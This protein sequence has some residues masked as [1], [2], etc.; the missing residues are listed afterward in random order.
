[1]P[2]LGVLHSASIAL[3]QEFTELRLWQDI[4]LA[5]Y[6]AYV[7][8]PGQTEIQVADEGSQHVDHDGNIRRERFVL[9]VGILRVSRLG[10][11]FVHNRALTELALN[12]VVIRNRIITALDWKFLNTPVGN[13][14]RIAST[15]SD[16]NTIIFDGADHRVEFPKDATVWHPSAKSLHTILTSVYAGGK[17]TVEVTPTA[18]LTFAGARL[19]ACTTDELLVRP[20]ALTNESPT[21]PHARYS[22]QLIKKLT[23]IGGENATA[24]S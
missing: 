5:P 11:G 12:I 21:Q 24:P 19:L 18:S 10:H 20:L 13:V 14:L 22:G 9:G 16:K 8:S 2:A 17:T 6:I 3:A 15:E 23:F 1:M 4:Y 7:P